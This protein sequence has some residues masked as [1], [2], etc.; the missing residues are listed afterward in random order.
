MAVDLQKKLSAHFTLGEL[1]KSETASRRGIANIPGPA[2]LAA[3]QLLCVHVLEPVRVHFGRPAVSTS[4]FRS[5]LLN[6]AIKGSASSQHSR[7]EADDFTMPRASNLK[8]CR[9]I[10]RHLNYDQ[11]IYESGETGWI[12][13]SYSARQMRNSELS[14]MR[15]GGKTVYLTGIIA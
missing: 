6:A 9:W 13:C 1:T 12:P 4:G 14:A 8:V 7:G 3:L 15:R 10:H 2:E 11:L 5:P